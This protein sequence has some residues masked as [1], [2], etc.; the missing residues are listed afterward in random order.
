MTRCAVRWGFCA[1]VLAACVTLSGC[2]VG[3]DFHRPAL[4]PSAGYGSAATSPQLASGTDIPAQW[5]EIF[6]SA[7]LDD[8][9]ALALK[10][11]PTID[12]AKAALRSAR[13]QRIAQQGAYY[14]TIGASLQ[15]SHQDVAR[16]LSSP[17]ES[18]SNVFDLTTT[19]VSV[20]YTRTSSGPTSGR[21]NH[22]PRRKTSSDFSLRPRG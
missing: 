21:W 11:N 18:N 4:S 9:V 1:S 14:P 17:L 19:Q 5:W 10:N 8:L 12:A 20:A 6:H 16:S 3:P 13:E 7:E 22:W 2:V 15:P